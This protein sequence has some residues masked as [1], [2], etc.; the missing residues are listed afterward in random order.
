MEQLLFSPQEAADALGVSLSTIYRRL[1]DGSLQHTRL[2]NRRMIPREI[3]LR[4][5]M[6]PTK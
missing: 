3:I 6:V 4:A 1:E 2:G 5:G